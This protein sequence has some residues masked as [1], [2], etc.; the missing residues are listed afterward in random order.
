MA[1]DLTDDALDGAVRDVT[2][3]ELYIQLS[4][5]VVVLRAVHGASL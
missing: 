2:Q 4:T 5:V 3:L 1:P